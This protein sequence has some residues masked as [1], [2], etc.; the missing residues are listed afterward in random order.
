MVHGNS[1]ALRAVLDD[2]EALGVGRIV[3]L[4]DCVYGPLDPSGTADILIS[5]KIVSVRGN[6]DRILTATSDQEGGGGEPPGDATQNPSLRFT[7]ERLTGSQL[8][9]ISSL[10]PELHIDPGIYLC[11]GSPGD[12]T[13][14]LLWTV[15]EAGARRSTE[16]EISARLSGVGASVILCGHD[17]LQG[18]KRLPDGRLVVDPGSVGLQAYTDDAPYHHFMESGSPHARYSVLRG[19]SG[20]WD[21]EHRRVTYDWDEAAGMAADNGRPDWAQW[22][23]TGLADFSIL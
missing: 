18:D 10:P 1:P 12:D 8:A 6:E 16:E 7:R 13:K 20:G 17:H 14:Y 3:N 22:L 9:W 4:G 21:V 5:R 23:R 2:I 15:D 19:S 11:H